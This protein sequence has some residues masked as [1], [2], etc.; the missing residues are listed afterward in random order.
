MLKSMNLYIF[1]NMLILLKTVQK[2]QGEGVNTYL[3]LLCEKI[4]V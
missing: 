4:D 3:E 2:M 1:C